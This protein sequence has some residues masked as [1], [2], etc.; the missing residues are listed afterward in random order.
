VD[1]ELVTDVDLLQQYVSGWEGLADRVSQPRAGG[2]I[3]A[4]W[5]QHMMGPD[6]E[7]R[8]WVALDH[9]EVVGVL[10]FVAEKM[11]RGRLRLLPPATNMMYGVVP[12]AHPDCGSEVVEAIADDFAARSELVD[13]TSIFWLPEGS[14][15]TDALGSRLGG[16]EWV[17]TDTTHFTSYFTRVGVGIDAWLHQRSGK[18][19][20]EVRRQARRFNEEGFRLFTAVEPGDIMEWLPQLRSLYVRR[21][22]EREGE[23]YEFAEGMSS[24]IATTLDL[25]ARG[26][27]ALSGLQR[28]GM[29]IGAAM[30][31]VAGTRMSGWLIAFDR[32]WARFGPGIAV[33]LECLAAGARAGCDVADLGVGDQPYKDDFQDATFPLESVT[34]CRPRLARLLQLG[35]PPTPAAPVDE[36]ARVDRVPGV[37]A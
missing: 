25:S 10:P 23:G 12:I 4:G 11:A 29:V 22:E 17:A 8:I 26:H 1:V 6:S 2:A 35:S 13:L 20:R 21:Q 27:L 28:D 15:W 18:F 5:A 33:V 30:A 36:G 3:V 9:S 34:W 24:A 16:S 19:R 7:L 37:G 31:A 14:P 32:E